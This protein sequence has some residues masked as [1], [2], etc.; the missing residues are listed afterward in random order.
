MTE[1][2]TV[3]G[4]PEARPVVSAGP[5]TADGPDWHWEQLPSGWWVPQANDIPPISQR[6]PDQWWYWTP[7]WQAGEREI[8][9][10]RAAGLTGPG[11][12]D[13]D[14]FLAFLAREADLTV[15]ELERLA[16]EG[17]PPERE[18]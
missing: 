18:G 5:P 8:E 17:S 16:A 15:E 6:D 11:I 4:W 3:S 2:K 7:Q 14:E 9:T 13:G 1:P 10:D 12:M